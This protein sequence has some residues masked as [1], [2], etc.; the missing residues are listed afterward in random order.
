MAVEKQ[1][2]ANK[3]DFMIYEV[4]LSEF[5]DPDKHFKMSVDSAL[6]SRWTRISATTVGISHRWGC[7][8]QYIW[9][10]NAAVISS[11]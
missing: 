6:K 7:L 3:N 11:I 9:T 10:V 5:Q 2:K 1:A 4:V 8:D